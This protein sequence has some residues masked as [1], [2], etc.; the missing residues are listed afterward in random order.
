M[1][2]LQALCPCEYTTGN[3]RRK[4]TPRGS[5]WPD[6]GSKSDNGISDGWNRESGA[7]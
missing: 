4:T 1:Q 7:Q 6:P 5:K 3:M 2:A